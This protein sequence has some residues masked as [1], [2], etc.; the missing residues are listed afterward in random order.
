MERHDLDIRGVLAAVGNNFKQMWNFTMFMARLSIFRGCGC[1]HKLETSNFV[2]DATY[3][4]IHQ[5][6]VFLKKGHS[7]NYIIRQGVRNY[8]AYRFRYV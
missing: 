7:Q 3:R 4:S 6:G 5:N 1:L 8:G 2:S